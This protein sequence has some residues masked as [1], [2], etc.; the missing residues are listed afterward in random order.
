MPRTYVF[1][2]DRC[3]KRKERKD[4]DYLSHDWRSL[5]I[6]GLSQLMCDDCN[7]DFV[8]WWRTTK[9]KTSLDKR[10]DS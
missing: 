7:K 5:G 9:S 2:C 1:E 6:E 3:G 10:E 4:G 8:E